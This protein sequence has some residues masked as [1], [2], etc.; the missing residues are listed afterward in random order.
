M[1]LRRIYLILIQIGGFFQVDLY[2]LNDA[3]S[4]TKAK[5][6]LTEASYLIQ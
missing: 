2:S 1:S 4:E 3:M 5:A 6:N